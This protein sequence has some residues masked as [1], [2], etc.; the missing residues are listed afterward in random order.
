M[1]RLEDIM[2]C[3]KDCSKQDERQ[4]TDTRMRIRIYTPEWHEHKST[5]GENNA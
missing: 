3:I 2:S 5:R 4:E 1:D